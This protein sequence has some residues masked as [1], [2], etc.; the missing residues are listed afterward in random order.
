M[1]RRK[2][3]RDDRVMR[4]TRMAGGKLY[5][6]LEGTVRKTGARGVQ[7]NWDDGTQNWVKTMD[8]VPWDLRYLAERDNI[9]LARAREVYADQLTPVAATAE[10]VS[11]SP[12]G[13]REPD[14]LRKR[15]P[16][17]PTP[18][19]E[20]VQADDGG[21]D[22]DDD[23]PASPVF[24]LHPNVAPVDL[25]DL[26]EEVDALVAMTRP[27]AQKIE[28]NLRDRSIER[29]GL[30]AEYDAARAR[31]QERFES[32]EAELSLEIDQL[33]ALLDR[34]NADTSDTDAEVAKPRDRERVA[35]YKRHIRVVLA[36]GDATW[37]E[38]RIAVLETD[39]RVDTR[40]LGSAL[41]AMKS[42]G[43]VE[44]DGE[45]GGVYSLPIA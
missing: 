35:M 44:H 41:G 38:I 43:E 16:K 11:T 2:Y 39:S 22:E 13:P 31:L 34:L 40:L 10:I 26:E 8:I 7:V 6:V 1:A 3:R 36:A 5:G 20:P 17:L 18:A 37:N 24:V 12:S 9:R 27:I 32:R 14:I 19:P 33:G 25:G 29:N 15:T 42:A 23:E 21:E 45:R 30:R 28:R 4:L